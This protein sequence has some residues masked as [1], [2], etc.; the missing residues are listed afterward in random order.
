MNDDDDIKD[1]DDDSDDDDVEDDDIGDNQDVD[2]DDDDITVV[3]NIAQKRPCAA[4][5]CHSFP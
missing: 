3:R 2:N 5:K 4:A 1:D